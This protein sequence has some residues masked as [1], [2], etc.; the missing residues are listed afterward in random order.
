MELLLDAPPV[1][2]LGTPILEQVRDTLRAAGDEPILLCG[3]GPAF[4]A[5]LNLA[6]VAS[7]SADCIFERAEASLTVGAASRPCINERSAVS[8]V[9]AVSDARPFRSGGRAGVLPVL[10]RVPPLVGINLRSTA[11]T[12]C[13]A[14]SSSPTL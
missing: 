13:C 5:G 2:A 11:A 8:R 1:N 7:L 10:G 14:S 3:A 6:E 4:S 9:R 12:H